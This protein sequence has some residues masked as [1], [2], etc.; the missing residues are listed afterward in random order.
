MYDLAALARQEMIQEGFQP[1]FTPA[2]QS[3]VKAIRA[4]PAPAVPSGALRDMRGL[5]WSS[6]DNDTSRD[7]D[8]IE[9]AE[10]LPNGDIRIRIGIADVDSNVPKGS[11]V[12]GHAAANCTT[13][14]TTVKNFSMLPD[15][16]STD[17]TS[18]NEHQDRLSMVVEL[19]VA[20]DGSVRDGAAYP[21]V[22]RS[23]APIDSHS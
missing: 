13:V 17:L 21:A 7:L 14:Y 12:D 6:I 1:D 20:A 23:A 18:L 19:T 5:P 8:Q 9:M 22:T 16:L 3:Q 11:P 15:D 2:V 4:H 10:R